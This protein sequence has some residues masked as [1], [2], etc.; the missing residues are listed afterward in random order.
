MSL[1]MRSRDWMASVALAYS[2][3]LLVGVAGIR[4]AHA[5]A[6]EVN[7]VNA[8]YTVESIELSGIDEARLSRSLRTE[9][10]RRVG[11]KF[12]PDIFAELA[13]K[14]KQELRAR[15]VSP[16]LQRGTNAENI[17]VLL[18]VEPGKSLLDPSRSRIAYY[19]KQGLSGAGF[20]TTETDTQAIRVGY[21]NN[22]EDS[23]DRLQGVSA[24]YQRKFFRDKV[25]AGFQFDAF[26]SQWNS[27]TTATNGQFNNRQS[28]TPTVTYTPIEGVSLTSGISFTNYNFGTNSNLTQASPASSLGRGSS[29]SLVTTLRLH[30]DWGELDSIRQTATTEFATRIGTQFAGGDY[31]FRRHSAEAR[32]AVTVNKQRLDTSFVVGRLDGIAP[33]SERFVAGNSRILRGW[34]KYDITPMGAT[35]IMAGSVEYAMR[36]GQKWMPAA[37]IDSGTVWGNSLA[38]V[39][40]NSVG[41]GIRTRD[42]FYLYVAFPLKEGRVE[43]QVMTGVN[44]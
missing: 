26:N 7:N 42:G 6:Q 20:L 16:K 36:V 38:K 10:K 28:Y 43:P 14:I 40:R 41:G 18:D 25:R 21:L 23:L 30:R 31:S 44:F 1:F 33:L 9:L 13:V 32:Y 5:K 3:G 29:Q 24:N 27:F 34:N 2:L 22:G 19:G 17:K 11:E 15:A 35:R 8:R 12:H 39:A 4:I 37:F